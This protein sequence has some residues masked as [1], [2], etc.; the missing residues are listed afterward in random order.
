MSPAEIEKR[1]ALATAFRKHMND[2]AVA[3]IEGVAAKGEAVHAAD[4]AAGLSGSAADVL[5][6]LTPPGPARVTLCSHFL[7]N[8]ARIV[9]QA[10]HE[11]AAEG[12]DHYEPPFGPAN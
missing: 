6:L 4:L 8:V 5:I 9:A 12:V 1:L 3:H 7:A 11:P 10:A 2:A